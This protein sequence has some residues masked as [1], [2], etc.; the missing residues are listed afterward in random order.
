MRPPIRQYARGTFVFTE[1]HTGHQCSRR[2]KKKN[3][4]RDLESQ[5]IIREETMPPLN[6]WEGSQD[7][8]MVQKRRSRPLFSASLSQHPTPSSS[9]PFL[10]SP[11]LSIS[12]VAE[13]EGTDRM[14]RIRNCNHISKATLRMYT[15]SFFI[16]VVA[17]DSSFVNI[18]SSL[19]WLFKGLLILPFKKSLSSP[20]TCPLEPWLDSCFLSWV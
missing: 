3:L 17:T 19:S 8:G 4:R 14:N 12:S 15:A 16:S 5:G 7:K 13:G 2:K 1:N 18:C 11:P 10:S 9:L 20:N 6:S